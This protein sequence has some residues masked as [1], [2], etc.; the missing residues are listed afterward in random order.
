VKLVSGA[1]GRVHWRLLH[2]GVVAAHGVTSAA[3]GRA[4]LRLSELRDLDP[5][6][7]VL[8]VG[9]RRAATFVVP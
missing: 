4:V 9:G 8:R 3:S 7:Y 5:G 6:R 1:S 2:E